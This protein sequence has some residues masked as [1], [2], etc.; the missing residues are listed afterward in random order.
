[1][2]NSRYKDTP[3]YQSQVTLLEL[4][5]TRQDGPSSWSGTPVQGLETQG[6]SVEVAGDRG[7]VTTNSTV[8]GMSKC[9]YRLTSA[10]QLGGKASFRPTVPVEAHQQT[11]NSSNQSWPLSVIHDASSDR[12]NMPE[13]VLSSLSPKFTTEPQL[14]QPNVASFN[15]K[16]DKQAALNLV[17]STGGM[18]AS[19]PNL[20]TSSLSL[21]QSLKD[22]DLSFLSNEERNRVLNVI[23]KDLQLRAY[24][25]NRLQ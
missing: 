21:F 14:H 7:M 1:M 12:Q 5:R 24:E 16:P 10:D 22:L 25:K 18:S 23:T 17:T 15:C 3:R 6:L 8:V 9:G 2:K 19:S 11:E 13:I 4:D 20:A